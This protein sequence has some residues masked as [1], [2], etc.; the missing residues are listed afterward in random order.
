[1]FLAEIQNAVGHLRRTNRELADAINEDETA[2]DE[3]LR[4]YRETI[5]ENEQVIRRK[6][7]RASV[8]MHVLRERNEPATKLEEAL[9]ED[10]VA[11]HAAHN[12]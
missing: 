3:D 6:L 5:E 9:A 10:I 1:M 11:T 8:F 4:L 12:G 7:A 2:S